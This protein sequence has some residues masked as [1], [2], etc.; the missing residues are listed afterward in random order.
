[1]FVF[2]CFVSRDAVIEH[3]LSET[4]HDC[5]HHFAITIIYQVQSTCI[6]AEHLPS[7]EELRAALSL[8]LVRVQRMHAQVQH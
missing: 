3:G 7:S 8:D 5:D 2:A 1:M 6:L 4:L